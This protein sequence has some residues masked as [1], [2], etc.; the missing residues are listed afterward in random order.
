MEGT[1]AAVWCLL[2]L[3]KYDSTCFGASP[4]PRLLSLL[5]APETRQ[6]PGLCL[7]LNGSPKTAGS[8]RPGSVECSGLLPVP[9]TTPM[10]A[11]PGIPSLPF[12]WA[13]G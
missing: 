4:T 5:W 10:T 3:R 13:G 1:E 12:Q 7:H 9:P 2:E 6:W 8:D 11:A